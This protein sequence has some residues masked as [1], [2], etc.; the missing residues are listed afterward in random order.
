MIYDPIPCG[1]E[2]GFFRWKAGIVLGGAGT[3]LAGN[4]DYG[5]H[6]PREWF[7]RT[8]RSLR[9]VAGNAYRATVTGE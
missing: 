7:E 3:K 6:S 1:Q 8:A 4:R 2:Q 5:I 9:L